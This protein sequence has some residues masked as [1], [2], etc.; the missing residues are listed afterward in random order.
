MTI[1]RSCPAMDDFGL[2]LGLDLASRLLRE[3]SGP[4]ITTL[5][6]LVSFSLA[7]AD[8]NGLGRLMYVSCPLQ[9]LLGCRADWNESAES[10]VHAKL[11]TSTE[12]GEPVGFSLPLPLSG[13]TLLTEW[14][15]SSR[16]CVGAEKHISPAKKHTDGHSSQ[17]QCVAQTSFRGLGIYRN[18]VLFVIR[19]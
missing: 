5:F 4:I 7:D 3:R 6:G 8:T 1:Y 11:S 17:P 13:P 16:L 18:S 19:Q 10:A 12:L 9:T 15:S 2:F 14:C